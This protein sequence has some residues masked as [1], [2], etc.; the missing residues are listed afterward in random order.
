[1]N[2]QILGFTL[3]ELNKIQCLSC[4]HM[5]IALMMLCLSRVS[6]NGM[7]YYD[8][9]TVLKMCRLR[10]S[11]KDKH[12]AQYELVK[13]KILLPS[14]YDDKEWTV[15]IIDSG[16]PYDF[17]INNI[18]RFLDGQFCICEVC[19]S[20]IEH[21]KRNRKKYCSRCKKEMNKMKRY[22]A[23]QNTSALL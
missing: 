22:G 11:A 10:P 5:K 1:L 17:I 19:K 9:E 13:N 6:K 2:N 12:V 16:S 14:L 4:Q 8:F 3:K 23:M 15:L 18:D 21:D 7:C 20:I